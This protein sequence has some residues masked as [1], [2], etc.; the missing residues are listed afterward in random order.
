MG[1]RKWLGLKKAPIAPAVQETRIVFAKNG[2]HPLE[3]NIV[4]ALRVAFAGEG[5]IPS[6]LLEMDG[7]SGRKYRRFINALILRPRVSLD[8]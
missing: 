2:N 4:D 6:N 7:M 1:L 5:D 3:T 8:T